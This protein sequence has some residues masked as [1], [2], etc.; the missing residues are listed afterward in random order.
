MSRLQ[1]HLAYSGL[2]LFMAV[3]TSYFGRRI[4]RENNRIIPSLWRTEE[5]FWLWLTYDITVGIVCRLHN[6]SKNRSI[7]SLLFLIYSKITYLSLRAFNL[8]NTLLFAVLFVIIA[9]K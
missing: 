9:Y 3:D 6:S 7:E 5:M 1:L 4:V 2:I 8:Y